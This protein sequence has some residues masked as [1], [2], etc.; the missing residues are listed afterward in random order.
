MIYTEVAEASYS[1]SSFKEQRGAEQH[2]LQAQRGRVSLAQQGLHADFEI[3]L[4]YLEE[5]IK[6]YKRPL[7]DD[8]LNEVSR[9]ADLVLFTT[10]A[11]SYVAEVMRHIDPEGSLFVGILSRSACKAEDTHLAAA[12]TFIKD[13]SVL[14]R[15][16]ERWVQPGS[17]HRLAVG[18]VVNIARPYGI[19]CAHAPLTSGRIQAVPHPCQDDH[20]RR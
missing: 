16:L 11:D 3:E 4:P 2:R 6:A 18:G 10:A 9:M 19:P 7:L 14:G 1:T 20:G 8:F 12:P 13:L 17:S 5:P 15:P